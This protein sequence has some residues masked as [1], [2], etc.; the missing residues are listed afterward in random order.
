[1]LNHTDFFEVIVPDPSSLAC[2]PD[3]DLKAQYKREKAR[4]KAWDDW[5][6]LL[7]AEILVR[8]WLRHD[9]KGTDNLFKDDQLAEPLLHEFA[10]LI[11]WRE[12]QK[13]PDLTRSDSPAISHMENRIRSYFECDGTVIITV[14]QIKSALL[15]PFRLLDKKSSGFVP[16]I[17]DSNH[18]A[19]PNCEWAR[20]LENIKEILDGRIVVMSCSFDLMRKTE[21]KIGG[22][23][24]LLPIALAA[25]RETTAK[26]K[27]TSRPLEIIATGG[28]SPSHEVTDVGDLKIKARFA[29]SLKASLFVTPQKT[30]SPVNQLACLGM[31]IEEVNNQIKRESERLAKEKTPRITFGPNPHKDWPKSNFYFKLVF[32][33]EGFPSVES[34]LQNRQLNKFKQR[35][36]SNHLHKL[37]FNEVSKQYEGLFLFEKSAS[38]D[39]KIPLVRKINLSF[40]KPDRTR[41]MHLIMNRDSPKDSLVEL[42]EID[43]IP[44]PNHGKTKIGLCFKPARLNTLRFEDYHKFITQRR[45]GKNSLLDQNGNGH[46]ENLTVSK[47]LHGI[48]VGLKNGKIPSLEELISCKNE[49][50]EKPSVFHY[51]LTQ[52]WDELQN[53]EHFEH[54]LNVLASLNNNIRQELKT[55]P[56]QWHNKDAVDT[57]HAIHNAGLAV[58]ANGA[59]QFNCDRKPWIVMR[60]YYF[61][62]LMS[63]LGRDKELQEVLSTLPHD[64]PEPRREIM[65][66]C[67]SF[68][69]SQLF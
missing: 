42:L 49:S 7:I 4:Q 17:V 61:L 31:G 20:H 51:I 27:E 10:K 62:W 22:D 26:N 45:F 48:G 69:R 54:G 15:L 59:D 13:I 68:F 46:P 38:G 25:S 57:C 16:A 35:S 33:T 41:Y 66:K 34:V 40:L 2:I 14:G 67:H 32:E 60:S 9:P 3:E 43:L 44:L 12:K 64:Y 30:T 23:S 55:L 50:L 5:Q 39:E 18:C 1:M 28:I 19:I 63:I 24:L 11:E 53:E 56:L 6:Q 8:Q 37:L 36:E 58:W 47:L 65:R 21:D 29:E 52:E